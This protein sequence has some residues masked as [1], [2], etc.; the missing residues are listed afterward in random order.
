MLGQ[1]MCVFETKMNLR[2]KKI[3]RND[4][5]MKPYEQYSSQQV[6][7]NENNEKHGNIVHNSLSAY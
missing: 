1:Y 5:S 4:S 7:N 2:Q 6:L 3:Y